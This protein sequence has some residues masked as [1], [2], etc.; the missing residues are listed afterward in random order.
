MVFFN[1]LYDFGD[2]EVVRTYAMKIDIGLRQI[3]NTYNLQTIKGLS[4]AI[5]NEVRDMM[6]SAQKLTAESKEC[7]DVKYRGQKIMYYDFLS[8][9]TNI[10]ADIVRRGGYPII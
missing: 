5:R 8:I 4:I 2:R 6:I 9:L 3:E 10:S 1:R 7:L